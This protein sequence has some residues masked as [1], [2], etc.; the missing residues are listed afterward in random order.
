MSS[1]AEVRRSDSSITRRLNI[2]YKPAATHS[3][4]EKKKTRQNGDTVEQWTATHPH[5]GDGPAC[6][7]LNLTDIELHDSYRYFDLAAVVG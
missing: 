6:S 2:L 5:A 7:G 3:L 4:C 1:F